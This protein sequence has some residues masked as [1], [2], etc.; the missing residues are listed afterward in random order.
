MRFNAS[1]SIKYY[2][3][4]LCIL[5]MGGVYMKCLIIDDDKNS[6]YFFSEIAS[7]CGYEV[8]E[9]EN[10][11]YALEI[12]K[13]SKPDII[14]LDWMMPSMGGIEFLQKL[15][16]IECSVDTTTRI[17]MCS[18]K[19]SRHDVE[20]GLAAGAHEYIRKPARVQDVKA[21]LD[22]LQKRQIH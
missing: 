2:T 16:E 12:C 15:H 20:S 14:L 11:L 6:R 1:L 5:L 7:S 9:A 13:K 8:Y 10:G 3:C 22:G 18:A 17:V 21:V 4:R 19:F